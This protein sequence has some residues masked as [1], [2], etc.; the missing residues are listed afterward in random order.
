MSE[1]YKFN[2]PD[3]IY[4]IT[5]TITGWVDIFTKPAYCEIILNSLKYCQENKGL[6]IHAW[7]IMSSQIHLI[8]SRN[9]KPLLSEIL[10]DFK[11][12][13]AIEIIK[14]MQATNESQKHWILE[15][16][17]SA[18]NNLRRIDN[19]KVWQDGNHPIVLI[20]NS[21]SKQK[22]EYL[23]NNPVAAG[24]VYNQED[25]VYSSAIDYVGGK[26]LLHI[27]TID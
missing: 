19:Y 2:D 26:G 10:R 22:L 4:F 11:R 24:I 15:I 17:K 3:D 23:H 9:S 21:M 8:V 16:F 18:A 14:T 20:S 25:Y 7:V 27:E 1:K 6:V 5:P 12:F 13:T